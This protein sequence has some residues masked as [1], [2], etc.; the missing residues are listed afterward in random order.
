MVYAIGIKGSGKREIKIKRGIAAPYL[1]LTG[2]T[3]AV[4]VNRS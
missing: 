3:P 1:F 4:G 2:H